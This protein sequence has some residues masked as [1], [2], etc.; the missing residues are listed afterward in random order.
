MIKQKHTTIKTKSNGKTKYSLWV[1][2]FIPWYRLRLSHYIQFKV[3]NIKNS[4][5]KGRSEHHQ[6]MFDEY[7]E[8]KPIHLFLSYNDVT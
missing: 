8:G 2:N 1:K 6:N 4:E 7:W 3:V 5:S